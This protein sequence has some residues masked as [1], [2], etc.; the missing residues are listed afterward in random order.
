MD[1]FKNPKWYDDLLSA[2]RDERDDLQKAHLMRQLTFDLIRESRKQ[3][4]NG[5]ST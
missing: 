4:A 3:S 2:I 5:G 1:A